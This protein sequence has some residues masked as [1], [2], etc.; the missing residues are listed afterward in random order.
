MQS[1]KLFINGKEAEEEGFKKVMQGTRDEPV[2][3]YR[4]YG[5]A[6]QVGGM[7]NKINLHDEDDFAMGDNSYHSSDSSV[8]GTVPERN[9]VGP[10]L[11]CYWPITSHWGRIR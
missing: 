2:N 6:E 9:L 5:F 4:G 3:G 8:W 7:I 11:L 10:A 1:P